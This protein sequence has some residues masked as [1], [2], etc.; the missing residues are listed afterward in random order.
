MNYITPQHYSHKL[1]LNTE[2][3][4]S[5]VSDRTSW[6]FQLPGIFFGL[7]LVLL[8][9]YEFLNIF[10]Q[11]QGGFDNLIS[12]GAVSEYEPLISPAFFDFVFIAVGLG[13]IAASV[14]SYIRYRKIFFD[15][16]NV[17]IINRPVWGAKK[18]IKENFKNYQGI[19]LRTELFQS[20]LVTKN[21]YIVELYH[22]DPD[23][24]IPLY[25]STSPKN[26]RKIWENYA[27]SLNLPA[28]MH[29]EEGLISREV[30][31]LDKPLK[32]MAEL[33]YVI[34][35]FD[36]RQPHPGSVAFVRR[37]D[38]LVL[39]ARKI[40]WD[41]Y[42][43]MAWAAIFTAAMVI[44]AASLNT[45]AVKNRL[46]SEVF[47]SAAIV[48]AVV[49]VMAVFVLFRKEKLVLK[50]YKIV[51]THKYM[52]FSTKHDEMLK[53]DIESI[54]ISENPASGRYFVSIISDEKN[55]TFGAK[56]PL[57]DLRW[58]KKFLIHEIIK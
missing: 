5:K 29:T 38:K 51:N 55:I 36:V 1:E 10:K 34:D 48:T 35:D 31:N 50:K 39:K 24:I 28:L 41:A 25:I 33:G 26:I 20:G 7:L 56:L 32:E 54:E 6:R 47:Y 14:M 16:K 46:G 8:G 43:I 12:D 53:D 23:K 49:I 4:P 15:G 13:M 18:S 30:R 22:K 52:L 21:K 44:S 9:S 3:L 58:I 57:E 11:M 19:R 42:N 2:K 37:K 27:R 45:E 40:V 17:T